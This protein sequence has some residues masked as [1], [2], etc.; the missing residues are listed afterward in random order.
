VY[1]TNSKEIRG[2]KRVIARRPF[3]KKRAIVAKMARASE[4]IEFHHHV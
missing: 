4:K 1:S 3:L 2:E